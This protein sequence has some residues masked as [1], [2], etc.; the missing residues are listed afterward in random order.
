LTQDSTRL[1]FDTLKQAALVELIETRG[2]PFSNLESGLS[3]RLAEI[4]WV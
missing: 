3:H 1:A 2:R 4:F